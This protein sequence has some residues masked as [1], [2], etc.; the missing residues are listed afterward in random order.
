MLEVSAGAEEHNLGNRR[1]F[2][3]EDF[4]FFFFFLDKFNS[5]VVRVFLTQARACEHEFSK[6]K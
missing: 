6:V 1:A 2:V 4:F 5:L 3:L